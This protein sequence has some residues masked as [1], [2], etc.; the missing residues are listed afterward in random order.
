MPSPAQV[1]S[2]LAGFAVTARNGASMGTP[3][4]LLFVTTSSS[5][6]SSSDSS[7]GSAMLGKHALEDAC[8]QAHQP[9][10][11]AE[12]GIFKAR[13]RFEVV[14]EEPREGRAPALWVSPNSLSSRLPPPPD[15][16][17]GPYGCDCTDLDDER[18]PRYGSREADTWL[19]SPDHYDPTWSYRPY[20]PDLFSGEGPCFKRKFTTVL[21]QWAPAMAVKERNLV[22]LRSHEKGLLRFITE[23]IAK[24]MAALGIPQ[25]GPVPTYDTAHSAAELKEAWA[26][27]VGYRQVCMGLILEQLVGHNRLDALQRQHPPLAAEMREA[28]FFDNPPMGAWFRDTNVRLGEIQRFIS[29]GVPVF[30]RWSPLMDDLAQ[31]T[32]LRPSVELTRAA[33]SNALPAT[34]KLPIEDVL[35]REALGTSAATNL[36]LKVADP[37]ENRVIPAA[38]SASSRAP[39]SPPSVNEDSF[40]VIERVPNKPALLARM[41][42]APLPAK[43]NAVYP[44]D[45]SATATSTRRARRESNDSSADPEW[46]SPG[47]ASL[48]VE[49]FE[50]GVDLAVKRFALESGRTEE[51]VR[52]VVLGSTNKKPDYA[53]TKDESLSRRISA[54]RGGPKKANIILP[55]VMDVFNDYAAN[56]APSANPNIRIVEG[57]LD[58]SIPELERRMMDPTEGTPGVLTIIYDVG[59]VNEQIRRL[60]EGGHLRSTEELL[61]FCLRNLIRFATGLRREGS[62]AMELAAESSVHESWW[63][64][65]AHS[66]SEIFLRWSDTLAFLLSHRPRVL[67]AALARGGLLARI[68]REISNDGN[69]T[70]LPT[71]KTR[72]LGCPRPIDVN[73]DKYHVDWLG[74]DEIL[75]LLGSTG[76]LRGYDASLWPTTEAFDARYAGVWTMEYENWFVKRRPLDPD[77]NPRADANAESHSPNGPGESSMLQHPAN[78]TNPPIAAEQEGTSVSADDAT[79]TPHGGGL[80]TTTREPLLTAS[81]TTSEFDQA[82]FVPVPREPTAE[83]VANSRIRKHPGTPSNK[84]VAKERQNARAAEMRGKRPDL[85]TATENLPA[86]MAKIASLE[87]SGSAPQTQIR[88]KTI[89]IDKGNKES[90][91]S[92]KP[93]HDARGGQVIGFF[94]PSE[95]VPLPHPSGAERPSRADQPEEAH[96]TQPAPGH[97]VHPDPEHAAPQSHTNRPPSPHFGKFVRVAPGSYAYARLTAKTGPELVKQLEKEKRDK[98]RRGPSPA[99]AESSAMGAG[100]RSTFPS[101][102][103]V[104]HDEDIIKKERNSPFLFGN[105]LPNPFVDSDD[106]G[107][108]S[109][110]EARARRKRAY[111]KT[112][113]SH[114]YTFALH[115]V[116]EIPAPK[117]PT[118]AMDA[119]S[120]S[121][122]EDDESDVDLAADLNNAGV[123]IEHP[124]PDEDELAATRALHPA[125]ANSKIKV[126]TAGSIGSID[127]LQR[128][129]Y[130]SHVCKDQRQALA[131]AP[132]YK[133]LARGIGIIGHPEVNPRDPAMTALMNKTLRQM[134]GDNSRAFASR[135]NSPID[136]KPGEETAP[137][138]FQISGLK[139]HELEFLRMFQWALAGC[140]QLETHDIEE[141][142]SDLIY[143]ASGAMV[144]TNR[145]RRLLIHRWITDP[146]II[147]ITER[148]GALKGIDQQT[149]MALLIASLDIDKQDVILPR[150]PGVVTRQFIVKA[151]DFLTP[152]LMRRL[153]E[154]ASAIVID[155][156][157]RGRA[158]AWSGWNCFVCNSTTHPPGMCPSR[159]LEG[160]AEAADAIIRANKERRTKRK[161]NDDA[162][163]EKRDYGNNRGGHGGGRGGR[164]GGANGRGGAANG[165][166]GGRG[167]G[168]GGRI[169]F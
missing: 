3:I 76:P 148:A 1:F 145:F 75:V 18:G 8:R 116:E 24:V 129:Q 102:A 21:T 119:M 52:Q 53:V 19:W 139:L 62:A 27:W 5:S 95:H 149:T 165:R 90:G 166:G 60:V 29:L 31:A 128:D 125:L 28:L 168:Q 34:A 136:A 147:A 120:I 150:S 151:G 4:T 79:P 169:A 163:T 48:H 85:A 138:A 103:N 131:K 133:I 146:T 154:A 64:N 56:G 32:A 36:P 112:P 117:V 144:S 121:D 158:E 84:D 57:F 132:G 13:D 45:L 50:Q 78:A 40:E 58:D 104:V 10:K 113:Q 25:P 38:V 54:A 155:T 35:I 137:D 11:A 72:S 51:E 162:S 77:I 37:R 6:R 61:T 110:S 69:F 23:V 135:L 96:A 22:R 80:Q 105:N 143:V 126:T 160:W 93:I 39:S 15:A 41:N 118:A 20:I 68:A 70:V 33:P 164:G 87:A 161:E 140:L 88:R 130:W 156:F 124:M 42:I 109:P 114:E 153:R 63:A 66:P 97:V 17:Q 98:A 55:L 141:V 142:P 92:A 46:W 86:V 122:S 12:P 65:P 94:N 43:M 123:A 159:V 44:W 134:F 152:D 73:G 100:H 81:P 14:L 74:N 107:Y 83:P 9:S 7:S 106:D 99:R 101:L 16:T 108:E 67:R 127:G 59:V 47:E 115:G 111:G 89:A 71:A 82:G 26:A 30:Y 2:M 167:G 91:S 157:L 49:G